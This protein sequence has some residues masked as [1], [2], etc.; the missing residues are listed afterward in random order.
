MDITDNELINCA[1]NV[2]KF[3]LNTQIKKASVIDVYDGDTITVVFKHFNSI[4][5][6]KIRLLGINTPELIPR[7]NVPNRDKIIE[8]AK[9]SRDYLKSIIL[10]KII[11]IRCGEFY[12]FGRI[13]AYLYKSYDD[14]ND[15]NLSINNQ[16]IV[17]NYATIYK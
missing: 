16:M 1:N 13:L 6:W 14:I 9:K 10:N 11:Y 3:T 2:T 5:K 12:N 15:I 4:N 17:N 8:D 7:R